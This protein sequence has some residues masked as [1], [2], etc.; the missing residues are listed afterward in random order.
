ME[1]IDCLNLCSHATM[2]DKA[3]QA[4]LKLI[5]EIVRGTE[6]AKT[7]QLQYQE[8]PLNPAYVLSCALQASNSVATSSPITAHL[9]QD[10]VEKYTWHRNVLENL[11]N[12]PTLER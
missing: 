1:L 11:L 12:V 4:C 5:A 7:A 8:T 9:V 3:S 6:E 10:I 2:D